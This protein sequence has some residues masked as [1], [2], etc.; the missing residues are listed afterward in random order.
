MPGPAVAGAVCAKAVPEER[1]RASSRP[2]V[3]ILVLFMSTSRRGLL[4][5]ACRVGEGHFGLVLG[6][7]RGAGEPLHVRRGHL[8]ELREAPVDVLDVAALADDLGHLGGDLA[9]G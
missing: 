1:T 4:R 8:L 9:R 3:R 7:E 2:P 5:R 6:L